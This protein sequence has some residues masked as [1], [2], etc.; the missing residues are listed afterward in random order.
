MFQWK[1]MHQ[2]GNESAIIFCITCKSVHCRTRIQA[3][4]PGAS[5]AYL[6]P[7][8]NTKTHGLR[9]D[10]QFIVVFES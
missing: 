7:D 3:L 9:G 6:Y 5:D 4:S 2:T 1:F 8:D 10:G